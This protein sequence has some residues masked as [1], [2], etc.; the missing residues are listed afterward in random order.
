MD[1][2]IIQVNYL[3][4]LDNSM[5]PALFRAAESSSARPL[6]VCL[7]TW[8]ADLT[9]DSNKYFERA[10]KRDWHCIFPLFRGPNWTKEACGSDLVVSDLECAVEFVCRE[11]NVDEKR[12]YIVG[13]SGGGHATLLMAGRRPDLWAAASA[14][15]P[16]SDV[17][18]WHHFS[19]TDGQACYAEHIRMACGG[20]PQQDKNAFAEAMHRSPVTFLPDAADRC[21]ID[22]GTGIHDGHGRFSVPVSHTLEAFNLL[23]A[24]NDRISAADIETIVKTETIPEHLRYTGSEDPAYGPYKVLLRR[25]SRLARLTLFEGAHD[26]VHG[27]AFG[28]LERQVRGAAPVWASG[29]EFDSHLNSELGR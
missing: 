25:T 3:S 7:H 24:E 16:I 13:G 26:L 17:A 21:I 15:C 27:P 18:K 22:I 23:A 29:D 11:V 1:K 5:Q 28:F 12:I 19:N 4:R 8:S 14:W 20:D 6:V 10:A 2:Q 9:Q